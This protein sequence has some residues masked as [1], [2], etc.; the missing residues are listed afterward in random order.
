MAGALF[1]VATTLLFFVFFAGAKAWRKT[2]QRSDILRSA[3][4][5]TSQVAREATRSSY[6]SLTITPDGRALSFLSALNDAGIFVLDNQ[7]NTR[8]Q[9]Y[10]VFYFEPTSGEIRR[11]EVPLLAGSPQERFPEPIERFSG[12][13]GLQPLTHYLNGG[14]PLGREVSEFLAETPAGTEGLDLTVTV[15]KRIGTEPEMS[16]LLSSHAYFRN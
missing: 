1:L 3:Q 4:I 13:S 9:K 2:D 15:R 11:R 14:R 6:N 16:L 8:W 12:P 7:G 10:L 5:V